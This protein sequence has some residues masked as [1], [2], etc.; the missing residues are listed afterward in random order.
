[1]L[2]TSRFPCLDVEPDRWAAW[3]ENCMRDTI[4]GKAALLCSE[5]FEKKLIRPGKCTRLSPNAVPT[6]FDLPEHLKPRIVKV[7]HV[8]DPEAL[9]NVLFSLP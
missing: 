4:P 6:I 7:R 3:Y 5:H 2:F 1:M 9:L 8:F